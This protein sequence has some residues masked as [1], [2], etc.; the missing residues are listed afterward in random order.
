MSIGL[1]KSLAIK[2]QCSILL[3]FSCWVN[4][5]VLVLLFRDPC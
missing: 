2:F 4:L 5:M 3:L 1:S